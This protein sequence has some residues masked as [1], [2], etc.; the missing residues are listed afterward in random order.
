MSEKIGQLTEKVIKEQI[1]ELIRGSMEETL[2][3]LLE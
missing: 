3:E 1:K 2:N